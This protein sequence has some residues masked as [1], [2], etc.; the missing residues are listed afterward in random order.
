MYSRQSTPESI[1]VPDIDLS[2]LSESE[3]GS[4]QMSGQISPS[5]IPDSPGQLALERHKQ[6][7]QNRS[8][9]TRAVE[10]SKPLFP[11]STQTQS[12]PQPPQPVVS[13]SQPAPPQSSFVPQQPLFSQPPQF[14]Q[15]RPFAPATNQPQ[16]FPTFSMTSQ[17]P[18]YYQPFTGGYDDE[19]DDDGPVAFAE[20]GS[21]S[22]R[23]GIIIQKNLELK[24]NRTFN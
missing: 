10:S 14:M 11:P 20:E 3:H 15:T 24:S 13:Q 16:R 17:Q 12:A 18:A 6:Q 22:P 9:E 5:E 2:R 21:M 23:H 19:D 4:A 8:D 7:M 1:D